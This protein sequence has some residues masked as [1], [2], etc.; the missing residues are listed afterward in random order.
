MLTLS[1]TKTAIVPKAFQSSLSI[2]CNHTLPLTQSISSTTMQSEIF[3]KLSG[4]YIHT[5]MLCETLCSCCLDFACN[6]CTVENQTDDKK[7]N[8]VI[9]NTTETQ[10]YFTTFSSEVN[11]HYIQAI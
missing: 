1:S 7:S 2:L 4:V 11:Q 6:L 3:L 9:I 8:F 5:A 10:V